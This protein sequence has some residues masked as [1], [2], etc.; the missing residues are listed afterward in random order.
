[1]NSYTPGGGRVPAIRQ[2]A[3]SCAGSEMTELL[4]YFAFGA[5]ILPRVIHDRKGNEDNLVIWITGSPLRTIRA[6]AKREP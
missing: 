5:D 1:M 3:R 4:R 2:F 6:S